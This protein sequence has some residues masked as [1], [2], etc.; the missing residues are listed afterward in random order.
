[1]LPI[2]K[3]KNYQLVARGLQNF[4]SLQKLKTSDT[5]PVFKTVSIEGSRKGEIKQDR[6]LNYFKTL[7]LYS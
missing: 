3:E 4:K 6:T 5:R 2:R 7:K 1:M